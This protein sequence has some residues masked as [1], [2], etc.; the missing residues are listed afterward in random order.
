MLNYDFKMLSDYEF[1][2]LVK[3]L[4]S[5]ELKCNLE[6][7]E[8]GKDQGID[9]RYSKNFDNTIIIQCKHYANSKYSDLKNT[10]K[11]ELP[12]IKELKPER[13]ILVT[14]LGLTPKRKEELCTLLDGYCRNFEDIYDKNSLNT[15]L[16]KYPEIEESNY[17]LWLTSVNIMKKILNN[18]V[19]NKNLIA[20]ENIKYKFSVYVQNK[21]YLKVKKL[22]KKQNVCIISGNPGVGK[23]TLANMIAVEYLSCDYEI[24]NISQNI[25]EGYKAFEEGKKQLFIF[26]DFLGQTGL[27]IKLNKNE[28]SEIIKFIQYINKTNN[29]KFI[30][31]TRG[32]ILNQAQEKYEELARYNFKLSEVTIEIEDYSIFDKCRILYNHLYFKK[33]SKEH[34]LNLL[35]NDITKIIKHKNYNPRLI[36]NIIDNFLPENPNEFYQEFIQNL[37]NPKRIWEIA[38]NRHLESYSQNLVLILS[39]F[40]YMAENR[41]LK[42]AFKVYNENKC[43]KMHIATSFSDYKKA[44]KE[45]DDSFIEIEE[46]PFYLDGYDNIEIKYKNPSIKDFIEN[47]II[48]NEEEFNELCESC[49]FFQQIA[50][51]S[52]LYLKIEN[53]LDKTIL[54]DSIIKALN[55]E[56]KTEGIKGI[57]NRISLIN[58]FN[59]VGIKSE[60]IE[61]YILDKMSYILEYEEKYSI[62][63]IED[64]RKI[65]EI[66]LKNNVLHEKIEYIMEILNNKINEEIYF[67]INDFKALMFLGQVLKIEIGDNKKI[68]NCSYRKFIEKEKEKVIKSEKNWEIDALIEESN[69]LSD[70]YEFDNCDIV[71]ELLDAKS[72]INN[73][74]ENIFSGNNFEVLENEISDDEIVDMFKRLVEN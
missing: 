22:L 18:E 25:D 61:K 48:E 5:K 44:L 68:V 28:D 50:N 27:D 51:L 49:I 31:T 17:K 45:L 64:I 40:T 4:L 46:L 66:L 8:K 43:K 65:I 37:N 15:L 41:E 14:S 54:V 59:C 71:K 7:F 55:K 13:Y 29:K 2:W 70:Y 19:Y 52:E 69:E 72:E 10:I 3:E 26:D 35:H 62:L 21:S 42:E 73:S 53:K 6:S 24:V 1:E 47:F 34:I 36:E 32:Y 74:I 20:M 60:K 23:T 67:S 30:L 58:E 56:E 38:Y 9:L 12:K 39:T 11:K 16:T 57:I 33:V 63:S